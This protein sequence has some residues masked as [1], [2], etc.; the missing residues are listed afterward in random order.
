MKTRFANLWAVGVRA[1]FWLGLL[2]MLPG[3]A[4]AKPLNYDIRC[5][6]TVR[7]PE[8]ARVAGN[9]LGPSLVAGNSCTTLLNGSEIFPA[10]LDAIRSAKKTITLETYIFW[11]GSIGREF[12]DALSQRAR[13]GVKVHVMLDAVGS[14]KIDQKYIKS[15]RN[16]GVQLTE[17][18]PFHLWDPGTWRQLDNRTHRKLMIVDGKIGF[19]GGVGIADEWRGHADSPKHWRDN[20][21]RVEGPIVAQLQAAFEDNWVKTTGQVLAGDDYFPPLENTGNL[22]MQVFK[23][24]TQGGSE[25]MELMMLLSFSAARTHIRMESAYFI[26]DENTRRYLLAA[27]ARG[28]R[29]EII[30]PGSHIDE[31]VVRSASHAKWGQLLKG[32]VEIYEYQPTMFHCKLL[33]VDDAWVSIGSSNLDNRSFQINDEANL[34]VLDSVFAA[35]QTKVFENDKASSKP[36]SYE[37]WKSRSLAERL[38]ETFSSMFDGEL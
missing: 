27:R 36:M 8:F 31:K 12:T 2:Q 24:S 4:A 28:V 13:A 6:C 11:S 16:A 26:P 33:V 18:H 17:Y 32:G 23:S 21:Y 38:S 20:H 30:V 3:C 14:S 5:D 37:R 19:T 25:N 22:W 9:L 34:N 7:D 29:V 10:M 15:M 35:G 1:L